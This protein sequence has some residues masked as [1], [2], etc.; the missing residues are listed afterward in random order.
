MRINLALCAVAMSLSAFAVPSCTTDEPFDSEDVS[1]ATQAATLPTWK[2][3]FFT[4]LSQVFARLIPV[5]KESPYTIAQR[6]QVDIGDDVL[7]NACEDLEGVTFPVACT[8]GDVTCT[9][10]VTTTSC[11]PNS[12]GNCDCGYT[13]G[14]VATGCH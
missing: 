13:V 6:A 14:G 4:D 5:E 3:K 11:E 9:C 10:Y 2:V 12:S 7:I 8:F 1:V